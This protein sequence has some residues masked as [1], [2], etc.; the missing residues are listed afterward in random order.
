MNEVTS[1]HS[2]KMEYVVLS[3]KVDRKN[4]KEYIITV[5]NID[6]PLIVHEDLF[7]SYRLTKGQGLT[8]SLIDEIKE[9]NAKYMAYI[10]AIKYL[11]SKARSSKQIADYL[12]RQ[13]FQNEHISQA[14][15]K[16]VAEGYVNDVQYAASFVKSKVRTQGK[17]RNRIAM[18]LKSRGISSDAIQSALSELSEEDELEVANLAASKKLR[19]LSGESLEIRRKLQIFLMRKGY[20]NAVIRKV[21]ENIDFEQKSSLE[22]DIYGELLDN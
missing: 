16:L 14:I 2:D 6:E 20:T 13:Q 9:E 17:G 7:I 5:S 12:R 18:E 1:N 15:D 21:M 10:K 19:N 3:V 11:G 4:I 8:S 22:V